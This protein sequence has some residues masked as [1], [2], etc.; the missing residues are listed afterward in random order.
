MLNIPSVQSPSKCLQR[1]RLTD[2]PLFPRF[3]SRNVTANNSKTFPNCWLLAFGPERLGGDNGDQMMKELPDPDGAPAAALTLR[4]LV[5]LPR[6]SI[7][8]SLYITASL[9]QRRDNIQPPTLPTAHPSSLI[10]PSRCSSSANLLLHLSACRLLPIRPL[11]GA[12]RRQ[13]VSACRARR[14]K[15]RPVGL[16]RWRRRN[17]VPSRVMKAIKAPL[18]VSHH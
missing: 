17:R 18:S 1:C 4:L 16:S 7:S 14:K 3:L 9:Y 8:A 15:H 12:G 5:R 6:N 10:Y 13:P 2:P 11:H